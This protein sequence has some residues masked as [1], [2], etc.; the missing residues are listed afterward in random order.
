[1]K[2]S[3]T[4]LLLTLI[5][6]SVNAQTQY[7][8]GSCGRGGFANYGTIFRAELD[9]S[10][11]H[12]VHSFLNG[13]GAVPWGRMAQAPNGNIYGVTFL[14]GCQ[15]SC[16]IYE[17]NPS[18]G[19]CSDVYDFYCS[20]PSGEPSQGGI[21]LSTDG[22]LYGLQWNGIIYKYDPNTHIYTLLNQTSGIYYYGG[23]IRASDN[24]LYGASANGWINGAGT[25]FKYD[26]TTNTYSTLYNFDSIHGKNPYFGS[27]MEATNGKLYG[28][29][30]SGGAFGKGVIFSFDRTLNAY[31]DLYDFDGTHGS[32]PWSGLIQATD[33][34]L[35]GMTYD[36]GGF[37]KGTIY[38][39]DIATSQN[40]TIH[41]FN[42]VNGANPTGALFEA[43]NG[44]LYGI[45]SYGGTYGQGTA[46]SYD[47]ST[48]TYLVLTNFDSISGNF[49][50]GDF[51]E[52]TLIN[53]GI[54]EEDVSS[55]SISPNPATSNLTINNGKSII[56][57][58]H[59]YNVLGKE[60]L[61]QVQHDNSVTLDISSFSKGIYFIEVETEQGVVRRKFVKE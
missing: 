45:A 12:T 20:G 46:F 31:T 56:Q 16:V 59:I 2:K 27:L 10:N 57:S 22:N 9:G 41:T 25:I 30:Q 26:L 13:D 5:Y 11:L 6:I 52:A 18:T 49:P 23:L 43:S 39:Y 38:S 7:L 47:L 35:Y 48:N 24:A 53:A 21:Y 19:T 4:I 54:S 34:K 55:F 17:Y 29:T 58:I 32:D 1:M 42:V 8:F 61:N 44:I 51:M 40:T 33:G 36:G 14:G 37:N 28:T 60:M 3:I 50:Q 15:D